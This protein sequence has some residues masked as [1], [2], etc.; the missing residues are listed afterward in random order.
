MERALAVFNGGDSDLAEFCAIEWKPGTSMDLS[1]LFRRQEAG[2]LSSHP[3]DIIERRWGVMEAERP[4]VN[5]GINL[6]EAAK[7][8]PLN[9]SSDI[10][11]PWYTSQGKIFS[12]VWRYRYG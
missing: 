1:E 4:S 7:S 10:I 8:P 6:L 3:N 5:V 9:K 11:V 2:M 12:L